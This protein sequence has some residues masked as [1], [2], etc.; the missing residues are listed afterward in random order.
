[1]FEGGSYEW[2]EESERQYEFQINF[3]YLNTRVR[4]NL[5]GIPFSA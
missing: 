4:K 1:M 5:S 2:K 3:I